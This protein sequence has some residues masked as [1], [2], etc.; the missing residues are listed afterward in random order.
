ML[1]NKWLNVPKGVSVVR[2]DLRM[3]MMRLCMHE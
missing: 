1:L 3:S 2:K